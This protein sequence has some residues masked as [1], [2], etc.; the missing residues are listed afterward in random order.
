[1]TKKYILYDRPKNLLAKQWL[2]GLANKP[3]HFVTII[4]CYMI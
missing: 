3:D 4:V 2:T 1:L